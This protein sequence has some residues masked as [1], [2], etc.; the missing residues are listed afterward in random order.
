VTAGQFEAISPDLT[1]HQDELETAHKGR[2]TMAEQSLTHGAPMP[3]V[4]NGTDD[5]SKYACLGGHR[6]TS[7]RNGGADARAGPCPAV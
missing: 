2:P 1:S 6:G 5:Q 4:D 3:A 7:H